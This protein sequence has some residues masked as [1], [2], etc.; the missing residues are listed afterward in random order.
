MRLSRFFTIIAGT[1]VVAVS[2]NQ[3]PSS[4][5]PK[6]VSDVQAENLKGKIQQVET[7]TYLIDS[8]SGQKG[9]LESKSI[10]KYD[11]NGYTVYY[12]N[13]TTKDSSTTVSTYD[14]T[15]NGYMTAYAGT[16]NGKP[17]SSMKLT[18]DST[19]G[20]YSLAVSFDSTGKED[21]FYDSIITNE[22]GQVLSAKGHHVDSSLKMTFTNNFD[23]IYY[24][25]GENKD[26]VGK[27]TYSSSI[28][29]NDKKDPQQMDETNVA[30]DSTTKTSTTYAY[31][32]WDNT[33]NWTQQTTT[34]N[35]KPKKI[36]ER[37]ITYKQ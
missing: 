12:S 21:V 36:I 34:E 31:N 15:L 28:T 23:S 11:D 1:S 20:K 17:L 24:V 9:R 30:K 19:T 2:C 10:E 14:H 8:V 6:A 18:V 3:K 29:L 4:S 26:S 13:Y 32:T 33:G 35:G 5:S 16:K 7:N 27:T 22:Y 25:G 37:T